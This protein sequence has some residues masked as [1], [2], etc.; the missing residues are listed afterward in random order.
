MLIPL[1]CNVYT[2]QCNEMEIPLQ[3]A[4]WSQ[5]SKT[6]KNQGFC[7]ISK[8]VPL[9]FSKI[10]GMK[11]T[12]FRTKSYCS[13]NI[14]SSKIGPERENRTAQQTF[15]LQKYHVFVKKHCSFVHQKGDHFVRLFAMDNSLLEGDVAR[16]FLHKIVV[17]KQFVF[18]R[19][20][21]FF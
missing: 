10:G 6:F 14:W 16:S 2:L 5:C 11:I 18:Y 3:S 17:E 8:G 13:A 15:G 19:N 12:G 21:R 20:V 9:C 4:S 7:K 1:Q